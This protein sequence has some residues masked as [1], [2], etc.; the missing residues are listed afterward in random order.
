MYPVYVCS[1]AASWSLPDH[2]GQILV[3]SREWVVGS[4]HSDCVGNHYQHCLLLHTN[5]LN[6]VWVFWVWGD[7]CDALLEETPVWREESQ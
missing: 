7:S 2:R 1:L 4:K 5:T 3:W 6:R